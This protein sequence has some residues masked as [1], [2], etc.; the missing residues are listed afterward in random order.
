M[1]IAMIMAA[2]LVVSTSSFASLQS[3]N[4]SADL[5]THT[6]ASQAKARALAAEYVASLNAM[7]GAELSKKLPHYH[8]GVDV[9]SFSLTNTKII[10]VID[11]SHGGV[12]AYKGMIDIDYTYQYNA[13]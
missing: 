4:S 3:A 2:S 11:L 9:N 8:G 1:K 6:V 10:T 5:T 13:K 7:S 12:P